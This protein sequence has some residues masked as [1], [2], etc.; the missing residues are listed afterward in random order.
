MRKRWMVRISSMMRSKTRRIASWVIGPWLAP[1]TL[2]K[3][4]SS[5][6]GS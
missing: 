4:W 6:L 2:A 3:T 1:V 5:R